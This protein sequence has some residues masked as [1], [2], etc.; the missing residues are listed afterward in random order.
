[1]FTRLRRAKQDLATMDHL[2]PIA[3]QLALAEGIE[4][5][6]AEHLV[7]AALHL[8]DQVA[9]EVLAEVNLDRAALHAAFIEQHEAALRWAGVAADDDAIDAKLPGP[10][11]PTGV[12][13]SQGSM[14]QVFQ[15]AVEFAKRDG[16]PIDS[17]HVL[18]AAIESDHGVVAR[19]LDR[20]GIDRDDLTEATNRRAGRPAPG[21]PTR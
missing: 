15:R 3:E 14:Q 20:I 10:T 4:Q 5:P 13:R 12:Y 16:L 21:A 1:M 6:G 8:D 18:L 7:V 2:F 11:S 9:A 17:G 19:A